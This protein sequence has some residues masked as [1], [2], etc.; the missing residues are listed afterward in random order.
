[1][2]SVVEL[3]LGPMSRVVI[4]MGRW[5]DAS[6]PKDLR[7]IVFLIDV[8]EEGAN[9]YT[10][11]VWDGPTFDQAMAAAREISREW[12]NLPII[13]RTNGGIWQ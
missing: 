2:S 13:D 8:I 1:M 3:C 10:V 9:G 11:G 12:G 6:T 5:D 7:P 4:E